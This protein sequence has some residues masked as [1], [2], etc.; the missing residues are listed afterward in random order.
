MHIVV[1][2][3]APGSGTPMTPARTANWEPPGCWYEPMW[4]P[5][6]YK[7][8]LQAE[9][10]TP[11]VLGDYAEEY[12]AYQKKREKQNYNL[13][14][15][16]L[17]WSLHHEAGRDDAQCLDK[18][19]EIWVPKGKPPEDPAAIDPQLLSEIAR[20]PAPP[21]KLSPGAGRQ[22]V[23]L[24][25]QVAF[26]APLDRVW[27]SA[28]IDYL[29]VR[30]VATTMATPKALTVKAGTDHAEPKS[31]TYDLS[32]A[33]GGYQVDSKDADCNITYKRSS[34][35]G[36]T[37]PFSASVVWDVTWT[38]SADP[39]G[40]PVAEPALPDGKS[41]YEQAVTVKEIQSVVRD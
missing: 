24:D 38:D 13:G 6:A 37:Y 28:S 3:N 30:I 25:T 20:L 34:G 23:N 10:P 16:G 5:K 22:V 2:G 21:V 29:G 18:E 11:Q 36:G 33:N 8:A 17:W 39:A 7:K 12:R 27:V 15:K 40:Q 26:K 31:C 14:K 9:S 32:K 41:T 4:K 19:R 35:K 1:R